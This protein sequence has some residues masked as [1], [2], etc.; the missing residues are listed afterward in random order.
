MSQTA[1][2][3]AEISAFEGTSYENRVDFSV[4]ERLAG[5]ITGA[6]F[7]PHGPIAVVRARADAEVPA[8]DRGLG[9]R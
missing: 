5:S 4:L 8:E 9:N 2:Y 6:A 7:W 1:L 3:A